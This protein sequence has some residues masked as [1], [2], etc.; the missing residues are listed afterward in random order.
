MSLIHPSCD[1]RHIITQAINSKT[2]GALSKEE[3]TLLAQKE[4]KNKPQNPYLEQEIKPIFATKGDLRDLKDKCK[5]KSADEIFEILNIR[6]K[7]NDDGT[8]SISHYGWPYE[9]YSFKAAG[10]DEEQLIKDVKEIQGNCNLSGSTLKTLGNVKKIGGNLTV[11]YFT[12]AEDLSSIEEIGGY[13]ICESEDPAYSAEKLKEIK[14]NPKSVKGCSSE[15]Y[16]YD[17][18]FYKLPTDM[19]EALK[20][21]QANSQL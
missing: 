15:P 5:N 12:K 7:Y 16:G 8:K 14:L 10:I 18:Y 2:L 19:Q 3:D 13:V 17:H 6:V 9:V 4:R 20:S 21:L 1:T 11:P